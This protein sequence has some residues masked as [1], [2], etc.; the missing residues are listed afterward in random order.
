MKTWTDED[1][2]VLEAHAYYEQ[3]P[4]D[5]RARHSK[6]SFISKKFRE[7]RKGGR[8]SYGPSPHFSSDKKIGDTVGWR[9]YVTLLRSMQEVQHARS[10]SQDEGNIDFSHID[11][12]IC[13]LAVSDFHLGSWGTD[14]DALSRITE[15]I[16]ET[17]NLYIV[18]LG[19]MEQMS[20]KLRNVLEVS[21]N[22]IPPEWQLDFLE[23]WVNDVADKTLFATWDNHSVMREEA[24]SGRSAYK[25][26]MSR[27]CIY[28][29]GIGHA[30]LTVGQQTYR[31]AASHFFRGRSMLNPLHSQMRYMRFEGQDRE[32]CMAGD[33]HVPGIM[34]YVDGRTTRLAMNVGALQTNSGYAKR[35]FSLKT[36]DVMPC[37]TLH[38]EKHLFTPFWSLSEWQEK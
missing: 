19:D 28:F 22:A 33:S 29:N 6:S 25:R 31:I 37:F 14:Y 15:E 7:K 20:I 8:R 38:P 32:I 4:G 21:D 26:L 36:H 1:I 18:I 11:S 17:P 30:D 12:P 23:S 24:A 13:V 16:V 3:T 2:A 27:K 5:F 9:E 34:K 35:F 10:W